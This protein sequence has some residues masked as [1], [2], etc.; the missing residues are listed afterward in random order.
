MQYA[1]K[2]IKCM[3][4]FAVLH[5]QKKRLFVLKISKIIIAHLD[6]YI[7]SW[8]HAKCFSLT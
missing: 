7:C 5:C 2:W 8:Y 6:I 4:P 1:S 3:W